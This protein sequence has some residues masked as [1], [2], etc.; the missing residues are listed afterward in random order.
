MR[1]ALQVIL[2]LGLR[3]PEGADGFHLRHDLARPKA[4][5]LHIRDRVERALPLRLV[6][7]IDG[8]AVGHATIIALTVGRGRIVD[9]EE[10][11]EDL[12]VADHRRIK[13]DLDPLGMGAVI[14]IGGIGDIAAGI[15]HPRRQDAGLV[16]DQFLHAPETAARQNGAFALVAHATS[17]TWSR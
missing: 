3:L 15:A 9:L 4:R 17:S 2:M 5:C 11:F 13:D 1:D 6:H 14:A 12:A 10:E 8:G 7:I 16:P